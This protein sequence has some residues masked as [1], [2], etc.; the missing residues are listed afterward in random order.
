[1]RLS[2]NRLRFLPA[3]GGGRAHQLGLAI[4]TDVH[5]NAEVPLIAFFGR[6]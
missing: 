4:D 1:M 3:D 5:L 6:F 2:C